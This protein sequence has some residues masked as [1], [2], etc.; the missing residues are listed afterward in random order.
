VAPPDEPQIPAAPAAS[1]SEARRRSL[2]RFAGRR[3]EGVDAAALAELEAE[4]A[5]L[6]EENA[7][8]KV[9]RHR[10]PDSGQVIDRMRS[11]VEAAEN[12]EQ[13]ADD[14]WHSLTEALVLRETLL[15]VCREVASAMGAMER[16]LASIQP[17]G[18]DAAWLERPAEGAA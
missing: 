10:T 2:L 18:D 13:A 9:E 15:D 7:R 12:S 5:L 6:R 4:L 1:P 17:S 14:A 16:R 8:L 3:S 11:L